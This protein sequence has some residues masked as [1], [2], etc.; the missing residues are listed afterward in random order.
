M[1]LHH[2]VH[3]LKSVRCFGDA[4]K[5]DDAFIP[6]VCATSLA[7]FEIFSFRF[8]GCSGT[9]GGSEGILT[10]STTSPPT[11]FKKS[12]DDEHGCCLLGKQY[13]FDYCAHLWLHI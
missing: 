11:A 7:E 8:G 10:S 5:F 9:L 1:V 12:L 13:S 6:T 4:L 3:C 2:F